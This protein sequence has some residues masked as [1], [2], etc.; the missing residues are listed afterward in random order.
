MCKYDNEYRLLDKY[1][2][3]EKKFEAK[4]L[5]AIVK[6]L[7]PGVKYCITVTASNDKYQ[8][9]PPS[10]E[11]KS[12]TAIPGK[13]KP[14]P[15]EHLVAI[16]KDS[17][18]VKLLFDPPKCDGGCDIK[19]FIVHYEPIKDDKD[20]GSFRVGGTTAIEQEF[21]LS[22][23]SVEAES[24]DEAENARFIGKYLAHKIKEKVKDKHYIPD[25]HHLPSKKESQIIP[26]PK[27]IYGKISL[28]VHDLKPGV[29]YRFTVKTKTVCKKHSYEYGA[30]HLISHPSNYALAKT[31]H[32]YDYSCKPI[33]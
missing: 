5:H 4:K 18:S 27:H 30:T 21:E 33:G 23:L 22:D 19:F 11:V 2:F 9:G 31:C 29:K 28:H 7:T 25:K 32:P 13:T 10:H 12:T 17:Y 6:H 1:K 15:P 16:P 3:F 20:Y 24:S 8:K 14:S 26:A